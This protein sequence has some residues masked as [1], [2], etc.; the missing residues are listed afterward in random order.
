MVI[1]SALEGEMAPRPP[2]EPLCPIRAREVPH[3]SCADDVL[4][5]QRVSATHAAVSVP[6]P[7]CSGRYP[8]PG[9]S[10]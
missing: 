10:P 3:R 9:R 1:K 2:G 6:K 8:A 7:P 4:P 5:G